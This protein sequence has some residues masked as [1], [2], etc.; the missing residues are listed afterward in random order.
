MRHLYIK[1][2]FYQDR[3]GTN[4]G[5]TPKKDRLS[6]GSAKDAPTL[7]YIGSLFETF[8]FDRSGAETAL[9]LL[10]LFV[11]SSF[12]CVCPE[13]VLAAHEIA[14]VFLRLAVRER[15]GQPVP[16]DFATSPKRRRALGCESAPNFPRLCLSRAWVVKRSYFARKIDPKRSPSKAG[17]VHPSS[18]PCSAIF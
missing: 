17:R 3:L 10:F 11:P 1:T 2:Q 13:P 9:S 6:S 15:M 14:F 18:F 16:N 12:L 7:E 5:N 8:D 4:V